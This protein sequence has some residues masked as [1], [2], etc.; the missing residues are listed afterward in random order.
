MLMKEE[1]TFK[2]ALSQTGEAGAAVAE[3][4]TRV[5]DENRNRV[6]L[7]GWQFGNLP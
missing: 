2:L 6:S 3:E 7:S 5:L 4:Q 1:Y